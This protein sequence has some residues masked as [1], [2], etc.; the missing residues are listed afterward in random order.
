MDIQHIV[1]NKESV[2]VMQLS[3]RKFNKSLNISQN[4]KILKQPCKSK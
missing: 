4:L 2:S 1:I 3:N